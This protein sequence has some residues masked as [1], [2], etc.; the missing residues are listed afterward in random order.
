MNSVWQNN[1]TTSTTAVCVALFRHM[2][3]P[4]LQVEMGRLKVIRVWFKVQRFK[5]KKK[6]GMPVTDTC[7]NLCVFMLQLLYFFL[8]FKVCMHVFS[9]S[10]Y[11]YHF[12]SS[13]EEVEQSEPSEHSWGG[14]IKKKTT[15]Q[16]H[17]SFKVFC[18]I[19]CSDYFSCTAHL[20]LVQI[21]SAWEGFLCGKGLQVQNHQIW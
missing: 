8:S 21:W 2:W 7:T 19:D 15:L 6:K 17:V 3:G 11:V 5:Q 13:V 16:S 10:P 14:E 1:D 18:Q 4:T 12:C 9:S 20:H